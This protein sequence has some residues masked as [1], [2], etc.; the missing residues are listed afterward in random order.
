MMH[1]THDVAG[2]TYS[3]TKD[4]Y[5]AIVWRTSTGEWRALLSHHQRTIAHV[6]YMT[7]QDAQAWCEARLAALAKE[8]RHA[9]P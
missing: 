3:C 9:D 2:R 4:G 5:Q 1:W 7:L 6:Q 8:D